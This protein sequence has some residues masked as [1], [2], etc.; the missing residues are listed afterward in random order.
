MD[1]ILDGIVPI[2]T[3]ITVQ[4]TD[5]HINHINTTTHWHPIHYC[6]APTHFYSHIHFALQSL[7]TT[8]NTF[9]PVTPNEFKFTLTTLIPAQLN[10]G[11]TGDKH[12][13]LVVY[14]PVEHDHWLY[15]DM[16]W[17][18]VADI[19]PH[20]P[21]SWAYTQTLDGTVRLLTDEIHNGA[22]VTPGLL[23]LLAITTILKTPIKQILF[24]MAPIYL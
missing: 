5:M 18:F 24:G 16:E 7:H 9:I 17:I 14:P 10:P 11:H 6:N 1:P 19:N 15:P 13:V 2:T 21:T 12:G 22:H 3:P 8:S 23:L 4:L 20:N